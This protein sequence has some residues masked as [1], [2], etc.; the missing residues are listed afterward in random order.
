MLEWLVA[1]E[2]KPLL[3]THKVNLGDYARLVDR[4]RIVVGLLSHRVVRARLAVVPDLAMRG[5]YALAP[6]LSR[7]TKGRSEAPCGDHDPRNA[8]VVSTTVEVPLQSMPIVTRPPVVVMRRRPSR[9]AMRMLPTVCKARLSGSRRG[10]IE[11]RL[12]TSSASANAH[13]AIQ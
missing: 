11:A 4:V 1:Y 9:W 3:T 2:Q 13:A 7:Q 10:R 8:G 5:R 6:P 12:D